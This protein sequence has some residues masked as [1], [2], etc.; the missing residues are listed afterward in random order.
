MSGHP[1]QAEPVSF[2][3]GCRGFA[4]MIRSGA[5]TDDDRE[6]VARR[7]EQA[8]ELIDELVKRAWPA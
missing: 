3:D 2:A 8:A 5:M 4:A 7:F 1:Q 6:M